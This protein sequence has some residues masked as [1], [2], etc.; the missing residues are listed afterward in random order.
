[1]SQ[2]N[3]VAGLSI[4]ALAATLFVAPAGATPAAAATTP[5][6]TRVAGADR[7]ATSVA[8]SRA[9]YPNASRVT[10]VIVTSGTTYYGG[11]SAGSVAAKAGGPLLL[12]SPT[13]LPASIA[14]EIKRLAPQRIVIAGSTSLVS[15]AVE[16]KLRALAPSVLRAGGGD[17]YAI[18]AA[19]VR[20]G[21]AA[22]PAPPV[23]SPTPTP[24]PSPTPA[25][26]PTPT[27]D[28]ETT[29]AFRAT[30]TAPAAPETALS[31]T[32]GAPHVY[33]VAGTHF[34]WAVTAAAL[35]ARN[36]APVLAV[37]GAAKTV[38]SSTLSLLRDLGTR[39]ITIVGPTSAVS[40]S[41]AQ[42]LSLS[43][44]TVARVQGG[45]RYSQSAAVARL[46]PA[47]TA[48]AV[49][50]SGTSF[51]EALPA[52]TLA[53]VRRVP[54]LLTQPICAESNLRG[55]V[56]ARNLTSLTLVGGPGS[57]RG[58]VGKLTTCLSTTA[59][60]S[61]WVVVNKK[62][63][64]KPKS[65]VP[66]SLRRVAGSAYLMRTEAASALERLIAGARTA[67]AGTIRV[68]SAYRSYGTQQRL[69]A[70]YVAS[71]GQTWADQQSARAGH[72]EHQTG[73]AADVVA[74]TARGCGSIYAFQGTSQQKWVAA[75][76]WRY[77]YVV[78]YESGYT[79]T[80]GYASEPW[81][82]R[83]VGYAVA[84]DYRSGGFRTLEQYFGYPAAPRY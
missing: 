15:A 83:Y 48:S 32:P 3:L 39:R 37:S 82:L 33:L 36:G 1:M 42:Q 2:R 22:T 19:L 27:P 74:C 53:A 43:G 73:L 50:A 64:L 44:F 65:F 38:P 21:F 11:M 68:N 56:S 79:G 34:T 57:V 30:A 35:A 62:N 14:A 7:Y 6:V 76:A 69:Y 66:S 24:A 41:I 54:V 16:S 72:S 40:A 70:G 77:G 52:I 84:S 8:L 29:A 49:V 23:P 4:L 78:R 81:H 59:A 12:T 63:P 9:A 58:L 10:T 13:T 47:A 20:L 61:P 25:P 60:T 5:A 51:T 18:S 17:R 67:G 31:G 80:T 26:E 75:N 71:R 28:P 46:F 45:D 55:Y